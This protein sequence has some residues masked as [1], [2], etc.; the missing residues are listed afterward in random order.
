MS[1]WGRLTYVQACLLVESNIPFPTVA[2]LVFSHMSDEWCLEGETGS[3]RQSHQWSILYPILERR[4]PIEFRG[5][6][7]MDVVYGFYSLI[8]RCPLKFY[9]E[10][11]CVQ[12]A[13]GI[14][15]VPPLVELIQPVR[16]LFRGH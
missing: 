14:R 5:K 10:D 11:G 12:G 6:T 2:S 9:S 8:T 13:P 15:P 3:P 1:V 7:D 16:D 4:S